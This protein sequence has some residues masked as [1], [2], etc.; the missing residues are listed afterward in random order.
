MQKRYKFLG[1]R[2]VGNFKDITLDG[3]ESLNS[4]FNRMARLGLVT[5]E[6]DGFWNNLK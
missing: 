3:K 2:G 5:T 4:Q 6:N 1:T